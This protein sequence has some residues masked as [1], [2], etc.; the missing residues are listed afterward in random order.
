LIKQF[1]RTAIGSSGKYFGPLMRCVDSSLTIFA[2]HDVTDEPSPFTEENSIWVSLE[3]FR[4]QMEFVAANFN[5]ISM[6]QMLRGDLPTRAAVITFD[7]GYAGTFKN[8]LTALSGMGLP[9]TVFMNMSPVFGGNFWSERIFYLC[10]HV[11]SFAKFIFQNGVTDSIHPQLQCTKELVEAYEQ[12]HGDGY[13]VDLQ[14]YLSPY[15]SAEQLSEADD[16][17]LLTLGSHLYTH[18]NVRNLSD[19]DLTDQYDENAITL[20]KY[21]RYLPVFAFPFG[22]PGTCFSM[23]Q[24]A[25]LKRKGAARLFTNFPRPNSDQTAEVLDRIALTNSHDR[26]SRLWFQILKNPLTQMLG[27]SGTNWDYR[28]EDSF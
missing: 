1:L 25:F 2:L 28:Q 8:G 6:D 14:Q 21:K 16:D 27:R 19:Q 23:N 3:N 26:D 17:P 7:D 12:E 11:P 13:F 9:S 22:H 24:A 4:K 5:V 20:S 15:V 10:G 18:Y